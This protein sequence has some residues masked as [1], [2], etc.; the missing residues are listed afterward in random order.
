MAGIEVPPELLERVRGILDGGTRSL[1][2]VAESQPPGVDAGESTP[3][4]AETLGLLMQAS[5]GVLGGVQQ[6][7]G[8]VQATGDT[9]LNNDDAAADLFGRHG[10]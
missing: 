7:A 6:M 4:V 1:E 3:T 8:D 9:Y 5:A 10:Q 2:G